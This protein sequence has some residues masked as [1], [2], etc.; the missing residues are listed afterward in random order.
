MNAEVYPSWLHILACSEHDVP[1]MANSTFSC[2]FFTRATILR[3]KNKAN[4]IAGL[5]LTLITL[6]FNVPQRIS[7]CTSFKFLCKYPFST[8]TYNPDVSF[9]M[10]QCVHYLFKNYYALTLSP[11][12]S[13]LGT[14]MIFYVPDSNWRPAAFHAFGWLK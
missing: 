5:Q 11:L 4:K 6:L 7:L 13:S 1:G 10:Q 2:N 8:E 12:L 3:E 14:E 9:D